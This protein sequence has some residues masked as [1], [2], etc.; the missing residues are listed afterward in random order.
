MKI[1]ELNDKQ[2]KFWNKN[3]Q[4][5]LSTRELQKSRKNDEK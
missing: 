3:Y 4:K 5:K 1:Y 2:I